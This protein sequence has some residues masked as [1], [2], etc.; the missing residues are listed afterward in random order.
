M[1]TLTEEIYEALIDGA[2]EPNGLASVLKE[3]SHSK[4]PFY[5]ALAQ[6]S[7]TLT[8]KLSTIS[9]QKQKAEQLDQQ[10]QQEIKAQEQIMVGLDKS[11]KTKNK[12]LDALEGK[13]KQAGNTLDRFKELTGL[14]F[15]VEELKK[16]YTLLVDIKSKEDVTT[17]GSVKHFFQKIDTYEKMA[18]LE[19]QKTAAEIAIMKSKAETEKWQAQAEAAEAKCKARQTSINI[20]EK[21]LKQG[22]KEAD[23]PYWESILDRVGVSPEH[24]AEDIEKYGSMSKLCQD[25]EEYYRNLEI[26]VK[27]LIAQ[28]KGV[29]EERQQI[30]GAIK[31]LKDKGL[32][33]I[34]SLTKTV[35][36]QV[37]STSGECH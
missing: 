8:E 31:E 24:L 27:N 9:I 36:N 28:V 32:E 25:R 1:R 26:Q 20:T 33:E 30:G 2:K 4:G 21:W 7:N 17:E 14:G 12:E 10:R 35:E 18:A 5:I 13:L 16:L 37:T 34:I 22:I 3:Y 29:K 6:A 19:L 11:L 23:L 15:G